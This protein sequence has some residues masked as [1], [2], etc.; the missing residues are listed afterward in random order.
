MNGKKMLALSP[1]PHIQERQDT[2]SIMKQVVIALI[3]AQCWAIYIFGF[4]ALLMTLESI[5]CCIGFE[6]ACRRILKRPQTAGDW[7]AAVTG[8]ILAMGLP[9]GTPL[10]MIAIGAFAAIVVTKQLF[11]GIGQ[12]FANPALVGCTVLFFSYQ[13][14]MQTFI[15]TSRMSQVMINAAGGP[16]AMLSSDAVSGATPLALF[17]NARALPSN[18][19]MFL[20]LINGSI[21]EISALAL[22]IGGVYLCA[23]KI[24]SPV[25]P[26]SYMAAVMV[27]AA[28]WGFDP[29]FHVCAGGVM[30]A[31]FFMATD[32]TT[33]PMLP[34]GKL[35]YGIGC[36]VLTMYFRIYT[37]YPE[38]VSTAML[39][40]NLLT[41][42]ID[43]LTVGMRMKRTMNG[44]TAA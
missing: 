19:E 27:M 20:G 25:I 29:V 24:I 35:I 22:L 26:L 21:G 1:A 23:R 36:G 3:P 12:N 9:A 44:R 40:M 5:V 15:V 4:G 38:G 32:Y 39:F 42:Q 18:T 2:A 31:A 8:A 33:S 16:N 6:W 37:S 43:R 13:G 30:L 41:P 17:S 14:R 7:S 34:A 10:W 28:F 11:G